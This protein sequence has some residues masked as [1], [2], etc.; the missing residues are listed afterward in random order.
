LGEYL[1][2]ALLFGSGYHV[3]VAEQ[4]PSYPKWLSGLVD[5]VEKK[6]F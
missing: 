2:G 6:F 5:E 4:L 1:G 3:T